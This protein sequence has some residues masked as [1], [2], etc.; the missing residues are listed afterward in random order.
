MRLGV[1]GLSRGFE[2]GR[3]G[4]PAGSPWKQEKCADLSQFPENRRTTEA[5]LRPG[6]L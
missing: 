6:G 2:H 5:G 1:M 3:A 4:E